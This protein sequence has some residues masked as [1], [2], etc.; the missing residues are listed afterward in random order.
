MTYYPRKSC[1]GG[2]LILRN[3]E[4]AVSR[5]FLSNSQTLLCNNQGNPEEKVLGKKKYLKKTSLKIL[6]RFEKYLVQKC[7]N[8]FLKF[9]KKM[10]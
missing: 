10:S 9:L 1:L 2:F 8:N 3:P 7:F 6:K 5:R 4:L